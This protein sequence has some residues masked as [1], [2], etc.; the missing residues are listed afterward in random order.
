MTDRWRCSAC[1]AIRDEEGTILV[2]PDRCTHLTGHFWQEAPSS[3]PREVPEELRTLVEDLV[4][5][6]RQNGMNA[7][8]QDSIQKAEDTAYAA[9]LSAIAALAQRVTEAEKWRDAFVAEYCKAIGRDVPVLEALVHFQNWVA[10]TTV[11]NQSIVKDLRFMLDQSEAAL[12]AGEARIKEL[13]TP[14]QF[15]DRHAETSIPWKDWDCV[16][17]GMDIGDV[18]RITPIHVLPDQWLAHVVVTR[19]E[20]GDPDETDIRLFATESEAR[21]ALG[22]QKP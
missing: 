6:A 20:N 1:H 4:D 2:G 8:H 13:E 12:Q 19:D 17:G 11:D 15:W 7:G 5:A 18:E 16:S 3:V 21:A 14:D 10:N 9:L 22:E